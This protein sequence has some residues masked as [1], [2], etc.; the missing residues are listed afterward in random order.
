MSPVRSYE[1]P[2]CKR[3]FYR[4]VDEHAQ[5]PFCKDCLEERLIVA[6]IAAYVRRLDTDYAEY[7]RIHAGTTEEHGLAPIADAIER[8]DWRSRR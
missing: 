2:Y 5:N 1:C 6:G 4:Y 8:G 3:T 7:D